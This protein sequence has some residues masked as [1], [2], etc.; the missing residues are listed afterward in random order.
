MAVDEE[1][2]REQRAHAETAPLCCVRRRVGV[3]TEA[4]AN[5]QRARSQAFEPLTKG[6]V[7][8]LNLTVSSHP[9]ALLRA[10]H[11][12]GMPDPW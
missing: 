9:P 8:P 4:A 11:A 12:C 2:R 10:L 1:P 3:A 5:G 7:L 6:L